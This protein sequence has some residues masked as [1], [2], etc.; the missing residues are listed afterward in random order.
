MLIL[1]WLLLAACVLGLFFWV[2]VMVK[3]RLSSK[4]L[5]KVSEGLT[6]AEPPQGWPRL[7]IVVP[8]HNEEGRI[9]RCVTS[10]RRQGYAN[11]Q[12]VLSLDRCTDGTAQIVRRHAAEDPRIKI[13]EIT[14]EREGWH[15]K[16]LPMQVGSENADGDWILFVDADTQMHA[17]LSRAAIGTVTSRGLDMLG[18]LPEL[19]CRFLFEHVVQPVATMQLMNVFP[20]SKVNRRENA[21]P[22]GLGPFMLVNRAVYERAGRM[23]NVKHEY[24]DDVYLAR[25]MHAAGGHV[26]LAASDGLFSCAMY[27]SY[28]SFYRGWKRIYIGCLNKNVKRLRR[29]GVRILSFGLGL[30]VLQIAA[31][32]V[33]GLL[34]SRGETTE[35]GALIGVVLAGWVLQ[36]AALIHLYR[37]GGTPWYSALTYPAGCCVVGR[38]LLESA[39]DLKHNRPIAWAGREYVVKARGMK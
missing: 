25:A 13:V 39:S 36:L 22:F 16:C 5:P 4:A 31:L 26:G 28:E 3:I 38:I 27:E 9:D 12:I 19:R 17:D 7:S 2:M 20:P 29:Y 21:R 23:E 6:V 8:I 35:G 18:V 32:V 33:G 14:Q 24:Q 34:W 1:G 11:L 10:L 37:M 15:G 30:P